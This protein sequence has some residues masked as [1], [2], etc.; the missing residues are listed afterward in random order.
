M[1]P[2]VVSCG[3]YLRYLRG[4]CCLILSL[5]VRSAGLQV[6][7]EGGEDWLHGPHLVGQ[8]TEGEEEETDQHLTNPDPDHG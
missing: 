4:S 7:D 5:R 1:S 3:W 8:Q 6:R 2:K